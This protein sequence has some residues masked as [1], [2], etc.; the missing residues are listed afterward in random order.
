MPSGSLSRRPISG[1]GIGLRAQHVDYVLEH[2]PS[3]PWFEVL[4]DNYFG[5]EGQALEELEQIRSLYPITMHSVCM[6][7]GSVDPIDWDYVAQIRDLAT[8]F[9]AA[10]V[11][12]HLCW[13]SAHG[14]HFHDLLPLPYTEETIVHVATRIKHIQ[15]FLGMQILIENVSSYLSYSSSQMSECEFVTAIAEEADC[16][17]LLD[18]NNIYVSQYN[19][20]EDAEQYICSIP[21]D[22]VGEMH[23]A[24]GEEKEDHMLD[25]HSTPVSDEVWQLYDKAIQHCGPI[26]TLIEWDSD[27]PP[28]PVLAQEAE[29]AQSYVV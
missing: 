26:P 22:R 27:I 7:I 10:W 6:S 15:D 5:P 9:E 11:S 16:K 25:T 28:F 21:A 19:H 3:I 18:V 23:L 1:A 4:T 2:K 12:E 14:V 24:G 29:K 17:I 20:G 13:T 8:R